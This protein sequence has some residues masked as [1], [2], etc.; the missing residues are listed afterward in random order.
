MGS[1]RAIRVRVLFLLVT[2]TKRVKWEGVQIGSRR[3]RYC[4]Y[5]RGYVFVFSCKCFFLLLANLNEAREV[6]GS[7]NR[8]RACLCL[9]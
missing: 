4:V 2:L 5:A 3:P 7:R 6:G 1:E 9:C 8:W